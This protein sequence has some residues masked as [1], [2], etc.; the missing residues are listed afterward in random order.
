MNNQ[1]ETLQDDFTTQFPQYTKRGSALDGSSRRAGHDLAAAEWPREESL[2]LVQQIFLQ[3]KTGAPQAVVFAGIDHGNGCSEICA[4]VAK[5]LARTSGSRVCLVEANFRSP[6][7]PSLFATT[8]H[9][10]LTDSL[11]DDRPIRSFAKEV[12]NDELYLLS[13]GLLRPDSPNLLTTSRFKERLLELRTEFDFVIIDAPPL[14]R[15]S[16]AVVLG[17]LSD[18]L[19]LILEANATRREAAAVAANNLRSTDVTILAAVLNKRSYP[20]PSK[21]YHLL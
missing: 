6:S 7:L 3:Q 16:D 11:S 13:A 2:R 5:T 8:N 21:I 1:V 19:V 14:T 18:G 17:Q 10:G 12:A 4:S 9:F 20:I 15:Y